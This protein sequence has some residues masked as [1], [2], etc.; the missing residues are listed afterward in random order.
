MIKSWPCAMR[1]AFAAQ[2]RSACSVSSRCGLIS[3]SR[4]RAA[5]SFLRPMS[6][7]PNST[8]R[9]KFVTSTTSASTSVI[10]PMPAAARYIVT[11]DPRPPAP[12][13]STRAAFSR[14]WPSIPNS[15][16]A[17]CRAYR[18]SSSAERSVMVG[19]ALLLRWR[20]VFCNA[21]GQIQ[22]PD[23]FSRL[24]FPPLAM[25]RCVSSGSTAASCGARARSRGVIIT[26]SSG[27]PCAICRMTSS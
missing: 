4:S 1:I 22:I 6:F 9:C 21:S 23:H 10:A 27:R 12:M 19:G 14:R 20:N 8:C 16:I 13:H 25:M 24:F 11:G 26:R 7:C 3:S 18:R 15:G 17:R 2:K 5:S